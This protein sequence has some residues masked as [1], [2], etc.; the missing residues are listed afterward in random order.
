MEVAADRKEVL[1]FKFGRLCNLRL[2]PT[3]SKLDRKYPLNVVAT[4]NKYGLIFAGTPSG[5]QCIPVSNVI[6]LQEKRPNNRG[7]I[8]NYQRRE[9]KLG[10]TPSH[11]GINSSGDLLAVVINL[12]D[13]PVLQIYYVQSFAAQDV[14]KMSEMRLSSTPGTRV[15]DLQWNPAIANVIGAV[16]S[17]GSAVVCDINLSGGAPTISSAP[18]SAQAMCLCWSPKGKQVVLGSTAGNLTQYKPDLK[19]VK[20]YPPPQIPNTQLAVTS[21]HWLSSFQFIAV[22]KTVNDPQERSMVMVVNVPKSG[23]QS[24]VNYEDICFGSDTLRHEHFFIHVAAWNVLIIS[25]GNGLEVSVLYQ[26]G[27]KW[28]QWLQDEGGRAELPQTETH[29]DVFAVGMALNLNATKPIPVGD[30]GSIPPMPYLLFMSEEGVLCIFHA[31]NILPNATAIC[32]PPQA[33]SNQFFTVAE[34]G[35]PPAAQPIT[36][37]IPA[38]KLPS[39][40]G[41][42]DG[43]AVPAP[44]TPTSFFPPTSGSPFQLGGTQPSLQTTQVQP[45]SGFQLFGAPGSLGAQAAAQPKISQPE[46]APVKPLP[47]Q[48]SW[49]TTQ[50][51]SAPTTMFG[52]SPK[53]ADLVPTAT[54]ASTPAGIISGLQSSG[55]HMSIG[56]PASTAAPSLPKIQPMATTASLTST[57][58]TPQPAVPPPKEVAPVPSGPPPVDDTMIMKEITKEVSSIENL[59]SSFRSDSTAVKRLIKDKTSL[60]NVAVNLD[61][62]EKFEKEL[63][64]T[65]VTENAE[66]RALKASLVEMWGWLENIKAKQR[67][68]TS[69]RYLD[70]ME[71]KE[72]D[73]VMKKIMKSIEQ[74]TLY[75]ETKIREATDHLNSIWEKQKEPGSVKNFDIPHMEVIYQTMAANMKMLAVQQARVSELEVK[76]ANTLKARKKTIPQVL[77]DS[78]PKWNSSH[79]STLNSSDQNSQLEKLADK[80]LQTRIDSNNETSRTFKEAASRYIALSN[81]RKPLSSEK[82]AALWNWHKSH[83]VVHTKA[84]RTALPDNEILSRL[85][86]KSTPTKTPVPAKPCAPIVETPV[87]TS[88]KP[89]SRNLFVTPAVSQAPPRS[90][91][92]FPPMVTSTPFPSQAKTDESRGMG[93]GF[94]SPIPQSTA[95][96]SVSKPPI[97]VEPKGLVSQN[98]APKSIFGSPFGTTN[99]MKDQPLIT[100]PVIAQVSVANSSPQILSSKLP[101]S[102]STISTSSLFSSTPGKPAELT[103][104]PITSAKE[105]QPNFGLEPTKTS[106]ASDVKTASNTSIFGLLSGSTM[107]VAPDAPVSTTPSGSIF[108]N[109][110][111]GQSTG[112]SSFQ[113]GG[114]P[115]G[116]VAS[117]TSSVTAASASPAI[118][119]PSMFGQVT[120]PV[121]SSSPAVSIF[122]LGSSSAPVSDKT[123]TITSTSQSPFSAPSSTSQISFSSAFNFNQPKPATSVYSPVT[124]YSI[125]TTSTS[126]TQGIPPTT[127]TTTASVYEDTSVA[128]PST[129]VSTSNSAQ[130]AATTVTT[131]SV[132]IFGGNPSPPSLV[133]SP[134][135]PQ[136]VTPEK[137]S[138][139]GGLS[140]GS[141]TLTPAASAPATT[142]ASAFG[143]SVFS[144]TQSAL[145]TTTSTSSFSFGTVAFGSGSTTPSVFGGTAP[146]PTT[147]ESTLFQTPQKSTSA[148]SGSSSQPGFGTPTTSPPTLISSTF[149]TPTTSAQ[150]TFS[151]PTTSA[152]PSFGTPTGGAQPSFGTPTTSAQP[153]FGTPTTSA[154]P[155]FGTPTASAQPAFGTPTTSA[156]PSFGTTTSTTQPAFGA[157]TTSQPS[158]AT[159]STSAPAFGGSTTSSSVFGTPTP[160]PSATSVFSAASALTNTSFFGSPT[161]TAAG[162]GATP[163]ANIFGGTSSFS[164]PSTTSSSIFGVPIC[165]PNSTS[166]P[167]N[168]NVFGSPFESSNTGAAFGGTPS[169]SSF[170][171]NT[172]GAGTFGTSGGSIFGGGGSTFGQQQPQQGSGLFQSGNASPSVFG[173][174]SSQQ[175][176]PGAFSSGG[177]SIQQTGFGSFGAAQPQQTSRPFGSSGGAIFG[178]QAAFGS[179]PTFGG[180][181]TFG[182]SPTNKIFGAPP[183]PAA[184]AFGSPTQ[185]SSTF[186]NLAG[187]NTVSFGNLAQNQQP[188]FGAGG[189]SAFGQ[190]PA[191]QQQLQQPQ[192]AQPA[193]SNTPA[194]GGSSFSSWR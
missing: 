133:S 54:T 39:A 79:W 2:F 82:E 130:S 148:F 78:N 135:S 32:T 152:L 162:F 170:R 85:L 22:Y 111:F 56:V 157:S 64:E 48:F 59:L 80:L 71:S 167:T 31:I 143:S 154:Q 164:T 146:P 103:K 9:H 177:Q 83:K 108:G 81:I 113:I 62:L 11:V 20:S 194:F 46:A 127:T 186:E 1:E 149:S 187:Q 100:S 10:S 129:P 90:I 178:G 96:L 26:E 15:L 131:T 70:T 69:Q 21:V 137:V 106:S 38:T 8:E 52:S 77:N 121:S 7:N 142:T 25:T 36:S 68:S 147:T 92:V 117:T 102:P 122:S 169:F 72:L 17:D 43:V 104:T 47:S 6:E 150:S 86:S 193:F 30:S 173:T 160:T 45:P 27:E 3:G 5:I 91:S 75:V 60:P 165:S 138:S 53:P 128:S 29:D 42:G 171:S 19:P 14:A 55:S 23:Q 84:T 175:Q 65:T 184:P 109:S 189:S 4:S 134:I 88:S 156:Q 115:F 166:A 94:L 179:A 145:A 153:T 74:N 24:F 57:T 95:P 126:I 34:A 118:S 159:P 63:R 76:L 176:S 35:S 188:T 151:P 192:Q 61:G 110:P 155:S 41:T 119:K 125:G 116:S 183:T 139:S 73:P 49:G 18:P 105:N 158:F 28:V 132:S 190:Q 120:S 123:V 172:P 89:I 182:G 174:S 99:S 144:G 93:K 37:G 87:V 180:T 141:M 161:T 16:V 40:M 98:S 107:T 67:Q 51:T 66:V 58:V 191:P 50:Q 181:A 140:F 136:L 44:K 101:S 97:T 12:Q 13:C 168:K 163:S 185:Q 114:S 112:M 124:T 33:L